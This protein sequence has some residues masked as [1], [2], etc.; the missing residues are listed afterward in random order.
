M[1]QLLSSTC[2]FYM[3]H[4]IRVLRHLTITDRLVTAHANDY[5]IEISVFKNKVLLT[6]SHEH[7]MNVRL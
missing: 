5:A 4:V 2:T 6:H 3:T 1:G 7:S